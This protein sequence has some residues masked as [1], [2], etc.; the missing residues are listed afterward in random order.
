MPKG[1]PNESKRTV[2]RWDARRDSSMVGSR[3][4]IRTTM[5]CGRALIWNW[6]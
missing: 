6:L 5:D 3:G 1:Q 2:S 4:R